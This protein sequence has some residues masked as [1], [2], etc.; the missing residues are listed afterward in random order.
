MLQNEWDESEV[1]HL[2]ADSE[3]SLFVQGIILFKSSA[4]EALSKAQ[5]ANN[6]NL[7]LRAK[8][9][10]WEVLEGETVK[11][12]LKKIMDGQQELLNK[13]KGRGDIFPLLSL[14][15][16]SLLEASFYPAKKIPRSKIRHSS[17]SS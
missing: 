3:F 7:Q 15:T 12:A 5:E 14:L 4:K 17:G 6:G 16:L 13:K 11:E 2:Q 10:T 9:V 1:G 8:D